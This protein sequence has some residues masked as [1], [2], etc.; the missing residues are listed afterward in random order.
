M[1][2][3][4]LLGLPEA[5]PGK[6]GYL[7]IGCWVHMQEGIFR[8][9]KALLKMAQKTAKDTVEYED[10]EQIGAIYHLDN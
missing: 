3:Y 10:L 2:I 4:R 1:Q 9:V 5:G 8:C 6:S 7:F